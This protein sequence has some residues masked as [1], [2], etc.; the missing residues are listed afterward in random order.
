MVSAIA[1][2]TQ[3]FQNLDAIPTVTWQMHTTNTMPTV[4]ITNPDTSSSTFHVNAAV[5]CKCSLSHPHKKW[6]SVQTKPNSHRDAVQVYLLSSYRS[7]NDTT[8]RTNI[9]KLQWMWHIHFAV[10]I[11]Q[12]FCCWSSFYCSENWC[13]L[14]HC[15]SVSKSLKYLTQWN[16]H[17]HQVLFTHLQMTGIRDFVQV[18]HLKMTEKYKMW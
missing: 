16:I 6:K 7:P 4:Q 8:S 3:Y 13:T 12:L 17:T 9:V 14:A 2:T 15:L 1:R 10:N 5:K 11:P 18:F